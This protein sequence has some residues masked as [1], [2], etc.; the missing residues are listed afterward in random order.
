[1]HAMTQTKPSHI[2]LIKLV[3]IV[4]VPYLNV[5]KITM[6]SY[7]YPLYICVLLGLRYRT[8]ARDTTSHTLLVTI[9]CIQ[10]M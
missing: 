10:V 3:I 2:Y 7:M 1:M 6:I 4:V 8:H 9:Y 5:E